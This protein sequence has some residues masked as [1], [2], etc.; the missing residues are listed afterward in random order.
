[1]VQI[2]QDV[3]YA[4]RTLRRTP[5]F[6][7]AALFSLALGI[8][9]ATAVFSLVDA[10]M[11]RSP[12]FPDADRLAVLNI[13]R[14][15]PHE[16]E[17]RYRWSWARF[18]L[19]KQ[20][21]RSFD[22]VATSSNNVVTVT[23]SGHPE[24]LAVEI[25]SSDYLTV[26]RAPLVSGRGFLHDD[27]VAGAPSHSV[28]IGQ[29]VALRRFGGT[30]RVVGSRLE[31]NGVAFTVVGVAA[32]G[33]N[34]VSGLAQA[35]IPATAAPLVT[36]REYL[37]TNQNFV[38]VIGRL[39]RDATIE[40]ARAELAVIG[41]RIHAEQPSEA[42]TPQ[43]EFSA[44]AVALNDARID[45][46][47]RRAL[48]LLAS[49]AAMLLLIACANVA[50]LLVG[51]AAARRRE[52]AIRLAIGSGRARLVRQMLTEG[53]VLAAAAGALTLM[54]TAWIMPFLRIP[55]TLARGRNFYGAVG[56]FATPHADWRL[57][58]FIGG[59]CACTV[60]LFALLPAL[61]STR[62]AIAAD[63]KQAG[64]STSG[65]TARTGLREAM[66]GLQVCLAVVLL[67]GCGLLLSSYARLR[68][69]TLGFDPDGLVTFMIRPSEAKYD[70]TAAPAL[71]A[72]VLAEIERVPG[73]ESATVD[74]CAPLSVQCAN[75]SLRIVG[76]PPATPAK[77]PAVLRHYV[78]PNH[79]KT[80]RVPII[81]GRGLEETDRAGSPAVVVINEA[82]AERFWPGED[83]IGRRVW[84]EETAAF[85]S[86]E[87]SAEI[88][89]IAG[90]VAYQPLNEHPI[91]PDFFTAY[92]QFTYPTRMVLVRA[93]AG[94]PLAL[95]PQLARAVSRADPD[96]ALFDVQT[97]E[98]RAQLS[99]SKDSFQTAL[100]VIF[101][102]IALS[103]AATG[104]FA[105]T[106]FFVTSRSREIGVRMA[107]GA[108]SPQIV[109]AILGPTIRFAVPGAA[110]GILAALLLGR[111]MRAALYE[112]SPVDGG[113]LAGAIAV[114][115]AAVIVASYFPVRRALAVNPV[116]VLRSE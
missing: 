105:V 25:V 72:R 1:M 2:L 5:V 68:H 33:F 14:R 35:W 53:A 44:T 71:L 66:V 8:G 47:T 26:M 45:I 84:F 67:V 55:A 49:A 113:V 22:G 110:A 39:R 58:A 50:G 101:A 78:S 79:F 109:R 3:R 60:L 74:G 24:P 107:L 86:P 23:G 97:M 69:A 115:M 9:S 106:Y 29:D 48:M 10:A 91:Q 12:P 75:A 98:A 103:V 59:V 6:T 28:V 100:F 16:G 95:V 51:R 15:T 52:I 20:Y 99:W 92:A 62:T 57:F 13:T 64:T 70:T 54:L 36:Y 87:N 81:R 18:Q 17:E 31:L 38:T 73:V 85:G 108:D 96:L 83:P 4:V 11:L 42:E 93:R 80:L 37:T 88:V 61:R 40:S 76:R 77:A 90:N 116:E 19:L 56:E 89:G 43:D 41:P 94:D 111:T 82:A 34:G 27:E 112:T 46:V 30:D 21:A 114:L 7:T 102:S 63:L 32:R 65:G 104:V